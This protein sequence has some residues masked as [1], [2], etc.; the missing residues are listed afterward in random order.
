MRELPVFA[1]LSE[2]LFVR[3]ALDDAA[4]F[5]DHDGIGVADGGQA[6]RDDERRAPGGTAPRATSGW[7]A[8]SRCPARSWP[9]RG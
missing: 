8:R 4:V 7:P 2:Q 5:E 1:V 6:V 9:R 3:A